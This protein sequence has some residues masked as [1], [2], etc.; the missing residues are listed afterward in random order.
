MITVGDKYKLYESK[1]AYTYWTGHTN[2]DT[3]GGFIG[4]PYVVKNE[5]SLWNGFVLDTFEATAERPFAA[6]WSTAVF[7]TKAGGKGNLAK[8]LNV[9]D[10][11]VIELTKQV[12]GKKGKKAKATPT[13]VPSLVKI[14]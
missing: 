12:K 14:G 8:F 11:R 7:A 9:K 3:S 13:P 5:K 4:F 2:V 1:A 6:Y 10:P